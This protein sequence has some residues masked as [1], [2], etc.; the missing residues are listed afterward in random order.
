MKRLTNFHLK[1]LAMFS[2]TL[3]HIGYI[4]DLS[5]HFR[6]LGRLAFPIFAFL[7]YQGFIHTRNRWYYFLRLFL[8][9]LGIE[10]AL[11]VINQYI[12]V[13]LDVRNIFLQLAMGVAGL[14]ILD[15]KRIHDLL[16]IPLLA[17]LAYLVTAFQVDYYWYGFLLIIS[18]YFFE[19]FKVVVFV[20]QMV[21]ALLFVEVYHMEIQVFAVFAWLFILLYNGKLGPRLNKYIF[22]LYYPLHLVILYLISMLFS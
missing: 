7:I 17:Y 5:L 8:F 19:R 13:Y 22:Y 6:I 9:G 16:K 11:I 15:T 18:F 4:F 21:L 10:L 20:A 2:M 1:L 12:P 14:A 3:D